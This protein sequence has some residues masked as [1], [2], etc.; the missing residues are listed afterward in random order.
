M[1][2]FQEDLNRDAPV[3]IG[4]GV[5]YNNLKFDADGRLLLLSHESAGFY[6]K[7]N[8]VFLSLWILFSF[9]SYKENKGFIF[10]NELLTKLYLGLIILGFTGLLLVSNRHLKHLY[11]NS[12]GTDVTIVLH[13]GFSF[14]YSEKVINIHD[15]K[16][17]KQVLSPSMR[18]FQLSYDYKS[19]TNKI[20]G[21]YMIFRPQY[22]YDKD[23]WK[24]VRT[25]NVIRTDEYIEREKLR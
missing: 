8:F 19:L 1:N 12:N 21:N 15:L 14:W 20:K 17:V 18:L 22:V 10:S 6:Y 11:L 7:I 16:G 23:L 2:E 24:L 4:G 13:K 3:N 5:P 9:K 25:G